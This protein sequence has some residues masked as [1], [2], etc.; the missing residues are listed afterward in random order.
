MKTTTIQYLN[1]S[2][3]PLEHLAQL[4][5]TGQ[6]A[7]MRMYRE[8]YE[9]YMN[10][11]PELVPRDPFLRE[12]V[13]QTTHVL[14]QLSAAL[15]SD[16]WV[17]NENQPAPNAFNRM[18]VAIQE[19]EIMAY[20]MAEGAELVVARWGDGNTSPVHGHHTGYMYEEI[21]FG[22]MKVHTYRLVDLD[23]KIVRP[24][25]TQIVGKGVFVSQYAPH[26]RN[27]LYIRQ[28]LIHSFESIGFSGSLH[29]LPEHTR[30]GR[31]NRFY[32]EQWSA[33]YQLGTHN[34]TRITA[35]QGM[36]LQPA[37][38]VLVRSTNVPEYGDHYIVVTG[39]AVM[40]EH[41]LRVQDHV[42]MA[43]P[44]HDTELLNEYDHIMGLT[45]LKLKPEVAASF[46]L[47]HGI[48]LNGRT[49]NVPK[50]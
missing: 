25:Q 46:L 19:P 30:D 49:V 18:I 7:H 23:N 40:K 48:T 1:A 14:S 11:M 27:N 28:T 22:K 2:R 8:G 44:D 45:L 39:P 36:S 17:Q 42:I 20:G 35:Q 33:Q 3:T 16:G 41:G 34:V 12:K 21:L 29:Y 37:D 15:V 4:T 50:P 43:D 24:L 31:D 10:M 13:T 9:Q 5:Y 26:N 38:V 47:F 32:V 6:A